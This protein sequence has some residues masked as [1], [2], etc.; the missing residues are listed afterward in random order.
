MHHSAY[1]AAARFAEQYVQ[2]EDRVLDVGSYDVN[3]SLRDL[4]ARYT[5][6]DLTEGPNVDVTWGG[7]R[8][9]FEDDQFDV[10]VSSSC[11]EH[12]PAFWV[13]F[14]EMARVAAKYLYLCVPSQG[15]YHGHPGD[16]WRFMADAMPALAEWA[17]IELIEMYIG[18]SEPWRD[19]VGIFRLT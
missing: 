7:R 14:A 13:T 12:D 5:G 10:C 1:K 11:L 2:A 3:G 6:L 16:C 4:F 19:N 9:P 17:G 18:D 15:H 8:M